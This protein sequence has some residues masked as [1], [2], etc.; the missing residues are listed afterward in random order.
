MAGLGFC[1]ETNAPAPSAPPVTM[2]VTGT[3]VP[4][5]DL[6]IS[7]ADPSHILSPNDVIAMT[8]YQEDDLD[9]KTIIDKNGNVMLPLL[10]QVKIGGM[11]VADATKMVQ[12]LY[13]KDYLVNPQ[14]NLIVDQYAERHFSVLGQVQHP[15][16]FDFPQNES[17]D[18]LQ[19]IAMAGSYTRLGSPSRVTV[20]RI[21]NGQP[22][23]FYVDAGELAKNQKEK[24]F[25]ILPDDIITVGERTF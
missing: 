16:S 23:L 12:Q 11:D 22:K 18:L 19:A 3:N 9:T 25:E 10:G 21:V 14:V 2:A 15:G 4:V 7:S 8:V 13:N 6:A 5:S 24:P 1:G 20:R 17:V